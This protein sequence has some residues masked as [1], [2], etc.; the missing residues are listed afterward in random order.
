MAFIGMCKRDLLIL[1]MITAIFSADA[2]ELSLNFV[3]GIVSHP[4][5]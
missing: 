5:W 2:A 1:A 4:A 3:R